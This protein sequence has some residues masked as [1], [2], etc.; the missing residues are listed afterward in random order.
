MKRKG[1]PAI[2]IMLFLAISTLAI[3]S[4]SNSNISPILINQPQN[5]VGTLTKSYTGNGSQLNAMLYITNTYNNTPNTTN[6]TSN[7]YIPC[8]SGWKIIHTNL[9]LTNIN[10]P[11]TT[12]ESN[13]TNPNASLTLNES[14][15]YAMSFRLTN[16]AYLDNICVQLYASSP[17]PQ[18]PTVNF[19]VYNAENYGGNPRPLNQIASNTSTIKVPLGTNWINVS[20][21]RPFLN[22]SETY[23]NTFFIAIKK[24]NDTN[25]KIPEW[26]A[27]QESS[28]PGNGYVY[29]FNGSNWLENQSYDCQLVV[30]VSASETSPAESVKPSDIGLTINGTTV[31]DINKG[32][33]EWINSTASPVSNGYIFY[34]VNS[35][36]MSPVSFSYVWNITI[37]KDSYVGALTT[38]NVSRDTSAFWNITVNATGS[39]GFPLTN[40]VN[41]INITGTPA[42]W[43]FSGSM[44]YNVSGEQWINLDSRPP[45]DVISFTAGNGTWILNCTAPNYVSDLDIMIGTETIYEK[46]TL[47]EIL[48]I[49]V[50]FVSSITGTVNLSVYD[51]SQ[52][53]N[54]TAI[55][56]VNQPSAS[57][58]WNVSSTASPNNVYTLTIFFESG[59]KVGYTNRLLEIVLRTPTFLT[60][61][62][63]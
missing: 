57:F 4:T 46:A 44:V 13:Y 10:A 27:T 24:N 22:I 42:D 37:L 9:T 43:D 47:D 48:N 28:P 39:D 12:I 63:C 62:S 1:I 11:N 21:G 56:P 3:L 36:W 40:G 19:Y 33:G 5:N 54:Y 58:T 52:I 45:D 31:S 15:L 29:Y 34:D 61:I 32:S 8:P 35:T 17:N 20:F 18:P 38:F 50:N 53:L 51:S 55:K 14:N 2:L 7:I 6:T 25:P 60:V 59:L 49:T 16:N 23:D 26:N 30:N 41:H